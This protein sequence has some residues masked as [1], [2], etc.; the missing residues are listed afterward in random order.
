MPLSQPPSHSLDDDALDAAFESARPS[1]DAG[2]GSAD[3]VWAP[4][5]ADAASPPAPPPAPRAEPSPL[6]E[7]HGFDVLEEGPPPSLARRFLTTWRHA[8]GLVYG[9]A[10]AVARDREQFDFVKG[11]P[12]FLIRIAASLV[13]PFVRKDLRALP[14][15]AQ[16]RRRLEILGPTY[17]K[18][19]QVLALRTDL[20]PAFITD[21]LGHLL[22]RLP[23]VPFDRYLDLVADGLGRPVDAMFDHVDP[24]PLGSASI[25]QIHRARTRD[26]DDVIIKVVKP[27]IGET[28]KR[29]ARLLGFFGS[30]L[31]L[32]FGKYQ[33]KRVID[34]F[35]EYT[36][37]EV[38][39]RREA[40][41][42][43]QFALNFADLPG[44][45][46][47]RIYPAFSSRSVL[48]MERFDGLRPDSAA[49]Q[50]LPLSDRE[51][52]ID[53]GAESIIRMLYRDGFFHADL[54]PGNLFI[55]RG[56]DG[57]PQLGFIDLGMVGYFDGELRRVLMYYYYSL[58]TGDAENAARYLASI[59]E[60]GPGGNVD[61]FR[62]A[63]AEVCRRFQRAASF[64]DYSLGQMIMESVSLGGRYRVYFPVELVLMV[65][66]LVT[67]EAVGHALL[68]D[69]D[70]AKLSQRHANK[71]FREKF[72]PLALGKESLRGL[73]ELV[74]LLV[75]APV[76]AADA[77]RFVERRV[78]QPP[79]NPLEGV[80]STLLAGFSLV[81]GALA[82][83]LGAPWWLWAPLF[84]LAALFGFGARSR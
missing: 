76:I 57:E 24:T 11:A 25:A 72:N 37:R 45:R 44:I 80:K 83:G 54:H 5:A 71:T 31:Q 32:F 33:P 55:L 29:D 68:P 18:L 35:T 60:P 66:A 12:L 78:K 73:P 48:T 17:I 23:V 4:R 40:D 49:A 84:G 26:G 6:A 65:K 47:P 1:G 56:G 61:G 62:K 51:A 14:L 75:H 58:V 36:L 64:R 42:A 9:A 69:F 63:V 77:L 41:N 79:V 22:D 82:A 50:A 8:I 13:R 21:E 30:F 81:S 70:V 27:N 16:L 52:L 2:P 34:E 7:P 53:L 46:F 20:F 10:V 15:E 67:F 59:A 19:G 43:R 3:D 74:D 28:L 38:D 39:L